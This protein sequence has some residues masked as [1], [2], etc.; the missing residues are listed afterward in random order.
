MDAPNKDAPVRAF[1]ARSLAELILLLGP[2]RDRAYFSGADRFPA[3]PASEDFDLATVWRLAEA[4]TLVYVNDEAFVTAALRAAGATEVRCFGFED[5]S[6]SEAVLASF[7]DHSELVFRGTDQDDPR[8][9]LRDL[10]VVFAAWPGGGRVHAGFKKAL[11]G[12]GL[13]A[14][15]T[16]AL[17]TAPRPIH[18]TGH[19]LGG[20][21]AVL[22]TA[23][24]TLESVVST[25][26]LRL[27]TF[28]APRT[29][30]AIFAATVRRP[31]FRVST[32]ADCVPELISGLLGYVHVGE[33][34]LAE[35]GLVPPAD[36]RPA[37]I[38]APFAAEGLRDRLKELVRRGAQDWL[39]PYSAHAACRYAD[40][41]RAALQR[42]VKSG[43]PG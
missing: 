26:D 27:T 32:A 35:D 5:P 23:R 9:W 4:A 7:S 31:S 8:D 29:G 17:R 16:Q 24:F 2:Q 11:D 37:G 39:G 6:Q 43:R 19:S 22:A 33:L 12:G 41:L 34:R 21:L 13:Y 10:D 36:F 28:G 25:A 20:A 3:S 15:L 1:G 38:L 40:L 42:S 30:D 18:C 14:R